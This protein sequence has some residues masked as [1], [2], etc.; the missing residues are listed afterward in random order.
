MD[1]LALWE[2]LRPVIHITFPLYTWPEPCESFWKGED[3]IL[4][5]GGC[6]P[7]MENLH[8]MTRF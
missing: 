3:V 7:P 8:R 6:Q 5:E 2:T 1:L 4:E